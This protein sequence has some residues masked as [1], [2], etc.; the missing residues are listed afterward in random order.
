MRSNADDDND[1]FVLFALFVFDADGRR[2]L[3]RHRRYFG[4]ETLQFTDRFG[5]IQALQRNVERW[6]G[7]AMSGDHVPWD[8]LWYSS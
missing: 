3:R 1:H 8:T 2:V 5:G 7:D 6:S 4:H